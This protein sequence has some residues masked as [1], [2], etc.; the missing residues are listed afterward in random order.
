MVRGIPYYGLS[1]PY[2]GLCLRVRGCVGHQGVE[3]GWGDT[4]VERVVG[5][6][7]REHLVSE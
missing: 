5:P 4:A 6:L 7:V 3:G 2:H 1:H